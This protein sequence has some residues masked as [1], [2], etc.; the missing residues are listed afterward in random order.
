MRKRSEARCDLNRTYGIRGT[1][2]WV[3]RGCRADFE[4]TPSNR[5]P[6]RQ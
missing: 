6:H 5:R 2:I 3:D 1:Q 4:V